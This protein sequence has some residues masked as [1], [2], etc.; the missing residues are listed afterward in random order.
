[1]APKRSN[2]ARRRK[3]LG[4]TQESLAYRLGVDRSTVLRWE[5][6]ERDP[7]PW[8][9]PRLAKALQITPLQ[10]D[11]LLAGNDAG[12]A[13]SVRTTI[14]QDPG[15]HSHPAEADDMQRRD[16]LRL[17]SVAAATF[18]VPTMPGTSDRARAT[19][20][21]YG[22]VNSHLWQTYALASRKADVLPLVRRQLAVLTDEASKPNGLDDHR[23]LFALVGDLFQLAGEIFFDAD[24]YTNA[25]HCYTLAAQA[26]KDA[27]A[28]DLWACALTR[29]AYLSVY[30][31]QYGEATRMLDLAADLAGHGDG[32]LSTRHWVAAVQAEAYAGLGDLLSCQR[33][34]D[35]AELVR[36]LTGTIHNGGWL[37]FDGTRLAE[38]RGACYALLGRLDLAEAALNDALRETLTLR[39]R[40]SVLTDLAV[41]G[42]QRDDP[43]QVV[44][45]ADAALTA[46]RGSGSGMIGRKLAGLRQHLLPLLAN[47]EVQRVSAEIGALTNA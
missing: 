46:A 7:Q 41:L 13:R 15:H 39:R 5:N 42:A 36:D 23:Q 38:G 12:T 25:A 31:R 19:P 11:Q 6:G 26:S 4:F 30:E 37:R 40:A 34:L 3:N 45:Y 27:D 9:R 24:D 22:Q 1:M 47:V 43:D 21:K 20:D 14:S 29:H 10:L 32:G 35:A 17:F 8:F 18:A 33:A 44:T 28:V 2:L 16:L